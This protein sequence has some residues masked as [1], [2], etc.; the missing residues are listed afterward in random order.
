MRRCHLV[1][2]TGPPDQERYRALDP[3]SRMRQSFCASRRLR[4]WPLAAGHKLSGRTTLR[5]AGFASQLQIRTVHLEME[6]EQYRGADW[7]AQDR[8]EAEEENRK[9][10]RQR[11]RKWT[12]QRRDV[13]AARLK[14]SRD[15]TAERRR[16]RG[17]S[18]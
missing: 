11:Y 6:W 5:I 14:K 17:I 8:L 15:Y 3:K 7:R 10:S 12:K 9:T 1:H 16:G 2:R 18:S 4:D 13:R